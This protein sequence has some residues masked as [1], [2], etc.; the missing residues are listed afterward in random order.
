[1]RRGYKCVPDNNKPRGTHTWV[2]STILHQTALQDATT[3]TTTT[4]TTSP[5]PPA[6]K[7]GTITTTTT[8]TISPLPPA[9]KTPLSPPPRPLASSCLFRL[10][11]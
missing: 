5:L 4:T 1:M 6:L 3:I 7:K 10:C 2:P 8:T 9:L 11:V